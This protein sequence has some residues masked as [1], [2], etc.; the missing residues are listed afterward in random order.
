MVPSY[1]IL[2]ALVFFFVFV[3]A[4]MRQRE[5]VP[6]LLMARVRQSRLYREVVEFLDL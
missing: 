5:N 6:S 4:R 2:F 3:Y 1:A